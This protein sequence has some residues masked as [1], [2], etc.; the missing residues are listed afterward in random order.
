MSAANRGLACLERMWPVFE[1]SRR[2]AKAAK[3]DAKWGALSLVLLVRAWLC[4][5]YESIHWLER[6]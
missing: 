2:P 4:Q 3:V 1:G 5:P 6:P